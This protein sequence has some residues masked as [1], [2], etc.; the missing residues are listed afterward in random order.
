MPE[1]ASMLM[2]LVVGNGASWLKTKEECEE[3]KTRNKIEPNCGLVWSWEGDTLIEYIPAEIQL[4][5]TRA[6]K[7]DDSNQI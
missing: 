1:V 6:P 3:K 7:R 5:H 2:V 4:P